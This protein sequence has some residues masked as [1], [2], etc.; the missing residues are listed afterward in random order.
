MKN[1]MKYLFFCLFVLLFSSS[2]SFSGNSKI[3]TSEYTKEIVIQNTKFNATLDDI[4]DHVENYSGTNEAKDRLNSLINNAIEIIDYLKND[5]GS[6]VSQNDYSHY[7]KMMNAYEIYREGLE[8]YRNNI[9]LDLSDERNNNIK[10]AEDK[11]EEARK[12]LQSI[13]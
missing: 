4:F 10:L 13:E 5:L 7:E 9:P 3:T 2:C 12:A 1:K 11:F 8:L 6:K